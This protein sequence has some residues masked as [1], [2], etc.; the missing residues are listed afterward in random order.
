M[1]ELIEP[2][3]IRIRGV[4]ALLTEANSSLKVRRVAIEGK[5]QLL[6]PTSLSAERR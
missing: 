1:T 6:D 5:A 2:T 4:Y 3:R